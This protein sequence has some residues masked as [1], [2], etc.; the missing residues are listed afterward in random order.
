MQIGIDVGATK[1]E[2]I[3]LHDDGEESSRARIDCPKDYVS[4]I[5]SIK[6]IVIKLEKD[7]K[8][9]LPV[10]VCHPVFIQSIQV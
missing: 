8:R 10:G 6:E 7:A 1:I 3:I 2:Y 4:I 9:E 5:K